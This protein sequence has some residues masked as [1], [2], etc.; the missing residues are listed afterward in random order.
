MRDKRET[1]EK[2]DPERVEVPFK[3]Q[4][5]PKREE[6]LFKEQRSK[7]R[8]KS[9]KQDKADSER[10]ELPTTAPVKPPVKPGNKVKPTPVTPE[11]TPITSQSNPRSCSVTIQERRRYQRDVLGMSEEEIRRQL[12]P[13]QYEVQLREDTLARPSGRGDLAYADALYAE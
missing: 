7:L 8:S 10:E 3:E 9:G 1:Q 4:A 6:V 11:S 2:A 5:D 13:G 12:P